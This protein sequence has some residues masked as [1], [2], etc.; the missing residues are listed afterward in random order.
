MGTRTRREFLTSTAMATSALALGASAVMAEDKPLD[1]CIARWKAAADAPDA[2]MAPKLTEQLIAAMGGMKRFVNK[3]DVVWVKPNMAWDRK[4]EQAA[5]TNPYVVKTIIRLCFEAGAK[6]VKV[7]DNTCHDAKKSYPN[8][9][10]EAAA[11]EA[12]A[13]VVYFDKSKFKV[14]SIGGKALKEIPIY[15]DILEANLLINV[16]VA[17]HHVVTTVTLA[18]KNYMGVV[19]ERRK[20]HEDLPGTLRDL[21][22]F[23]KP[24]LCII[25]AIRILTAN[26]PTGGDLHDVKRLNTMAASTDIVALD[27]FGCELL[28]HKMGSIK[29][30][31]AGFEAG[32]GQLDYKKVGLREIEVA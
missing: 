20:L 29:T 25:D 5:N 21:T 12:G 11:K 6:T 1:M 30:V 32:L 13:E 27:S 23:M 28:G 8:S 24:K 9:G 4:P 2:E 15:P 31:T 17:K 18:M 14:V 26:G 7:G 22:A 19:E 10:I 16:P 3:G